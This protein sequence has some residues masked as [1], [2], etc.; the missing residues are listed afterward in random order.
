MPKTIS[1]GDSVAVET[2][3]DPYWKQNPE[4]TMMN[5]YWILAPRSKNTTSGTRNHLFKDLYGSKQTR[6]QVKLHPLRPL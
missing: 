1:W 4:E 5:R 2:F 6:V 3:T